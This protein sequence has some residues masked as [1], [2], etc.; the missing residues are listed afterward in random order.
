MH[1]AQYFF[2]LMGKTHFSK[3]AHCTIYE[4]VELHVLRYVM[5]N[6]KGWE[7]VVYKLARIRGEIR[8]LNLE[9]VEGTPKSFSKK[10]WD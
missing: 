4:I 1:I 8:D 6:K 5:I 7:K 3:D 10:G 9:C 2:F